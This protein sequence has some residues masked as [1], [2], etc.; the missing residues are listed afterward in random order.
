MTFKKL[1]RP[2]M[3]VLLVAACL[4]CAACSTPRVAMTVGDKEYEMGDY[5][6]YMYLTA[7]PN[8]WLYQYYAQQMGTGILNTT[9]LGLTYGDSTEPITLS[10]YIQKSTQD[11]I[12]RQRALELMLKE[13]KIEWDAE[14]LAEVEKQ[15]KEA[16]LPKDAFIEL[17]FNNDRYLNAYKAITL[18]EMS[19][20]N[21]RYNKGGTQE[22]PE[23]EIRK[24]FDENYYSYF[25]IEEALTNSSGAAVDGADKYKELLGKLTEEFAAYEAK[26]RTVENF[27]KLYRK[28]LKEKEVLQAE[29]K[30]EADKKKEEADKN[31]QT[32]TKPGSGTTTTAKPTTTTTTT[33]ATTTTT[34][35]VA[36]TTVGA[37]TTVTGAGG[38]TTTTTANKNESTDK[39]ENKEEEK[40]LNRTDVVGENM[41]EELLKKVKE[42]KEGDIDIKEYKKGGTTKTVALI[43]RLDPEEQRGKDKDG[44]EIDY[45]ED[46]RDQT[47]QL[48]KYDAF[49]ADVEAK[50]KALRATAEL[51]ESAFDSVEMAKMLGFE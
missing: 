27:Q 29:I 6:A 26:D 3:A 32:T 11:T 1:M 9:D 14:E 40:T 15:I 12:F 41:D 33:K 17:G 45:Y 28:Y 23:T 50:V 16:N 10:D 36:T 43:F 49:N 46:N 21:G 48:L 20:F 7:Q 2:V 22:V 42:I 25:I 35:T 39:E 4:L 13:E 30:A 31:S 8:S 34:T 37:T 47:L 19:L 51:N 44:K 18:N 38:T 5:L 24:Y